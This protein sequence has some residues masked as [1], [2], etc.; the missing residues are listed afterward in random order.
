MAVL[1]AYFANVYSL[2]AQKAEPMFRQATS[3]LAAHVDLIEFVMSIGGSLLCMYL[4]QV[5]LREKAPYVALQRWAMGLLAVAMF[6][7]GVSQ[8]E[9]WNLVQEVY[10]PTGVIVYACVF[11]NLCVMAFRGRIM[12][13]DLDRHRRDGDRAQS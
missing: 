5:I 4:A 6:W 3:A 11:F 9:P 2:T 8:Y 7:N 10:R 12:R 13:Q 1:L